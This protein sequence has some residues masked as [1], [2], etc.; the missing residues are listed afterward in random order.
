MGSSLDSLLAAYARLPI[1]SREEQLLL[2]RAIRAWLDWEPSP[3]QLA[4]GKTQ[5]PPGLKR[6]GQRARD[7]LVARNMRLVARQARSFSIRTIVALDVEDLIQEGAI[8][9]CRA[10]EKFDPARGCTFS[11]YAVWW[12]RQS[13]NGLVHSSGPVKVPAKR[14]ASMNR[15]RPWV[16]AFTAREGRSPTDAEAMEALDLSAADL[17]LLRKAAAV[18]QVISLDAFLGGDEDGE[19]WG[20]TVAAP[21]DVTDDDWEVVL[22]VLQPWPDVQEVM[23]RLLSGQSHAEVSSAMGLTRAATVRLE[24]KGTALARVLANQDGMTPD[25]DHGA[26]PGE[27]EGI[28]VERQLSLFSPS[29]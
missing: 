27:G 22:E 6:A 20:S 28:L 24:A 25:E 23:A 15:L 29:A 7:Q 8:G 9:L 1:P 14:A 10:A 17:L 12:I 4:K 2:G 21:A 5:P 11:T 18:R 3:E 16:E 13:M 19:I 26:T